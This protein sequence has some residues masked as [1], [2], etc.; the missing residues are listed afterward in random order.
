MNGKNLALYKFYLH[1]SYIATEKYS[2][3]DKSDTVS[4]WGKVRHGAPKALIFF[5]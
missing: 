4:G 3:S 2:D 1:N 5:L